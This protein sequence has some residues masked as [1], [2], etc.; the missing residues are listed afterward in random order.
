[1]ARKNR[2]CTISGTKDVES[3]R[4]DVRKK[5]RRG[6]NARKKGKKIFRGSENENGKLFER[7]QQREKKREKVY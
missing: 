6:H 5:A 4:A 7:P 3:F 1:M 2:G